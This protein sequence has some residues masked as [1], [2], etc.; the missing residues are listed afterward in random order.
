MPPT[1]ISIN[2]G[3]DIDRTK[4]TFDE[5]SHR[6]DISNINFNICD[7]INWLYE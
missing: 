2:Q 1:N 6:L 7:S 3:A 4:W 5:D